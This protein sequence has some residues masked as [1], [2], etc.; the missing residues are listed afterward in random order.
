VK[1]DAYVKDLKILPENRDDFV[2]FLAS[3]D[4]DYVTIEIKS[5][6]KTRTSSQN[7]AI[8]LYFSLL[9]DAFNEAGIDAKLILAE[10]VDVPVTAELIKETLW[11]PIQKAQT[12]KDSSTKL[13]TKEVSEIYETV[14]RYTAEKFGISVPFPTEEYF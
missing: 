10:E 2:R 12:D 11:R 7:N 3:L 13:S 8:H 6:T 4:S 9:S 5:K 1:F 14:N